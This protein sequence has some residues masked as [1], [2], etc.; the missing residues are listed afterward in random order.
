MNYAAIIFDSDGVL[1][2]SEIL[3]IEIELGALAAIG[4]PYERGDYVRRFMGMTDADFMR[5]A[6]QDAR[7]RIGRPLPDNFDAKVRTSKDRLYSKELKPIPGIHALIASLD[8]PTAV[9][10]SAK[11]ADLRRNLRLT[12]LLERLEPHVYS[13]DLVA[14]G[15]PSPDVFLHAARRLGVAPNDCL[16]IED[17]VNGVKAALAAGMTV[18]GFLGGGHATEDLGQRLSAAGAQAVKRSHDE[19]QAA[20]AG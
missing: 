15:K 6:N 1:V 4:L 10:S 5:A 20:L 9:A 18:W 8:C 19:I 11:T 3:G 17:S 14:R 2:D 16:V 13:A 12:D 7:R